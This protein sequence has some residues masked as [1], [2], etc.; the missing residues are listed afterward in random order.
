[1]FDVQGRGL[2]AVALVACAAGPVD[3]GPNG[4]TVVGGSATIRGLSTSLVTINQSSQSTIINWQT[5]NVCN[6]KII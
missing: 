3:A 2:A 1:M 5:F 4:G 6:G